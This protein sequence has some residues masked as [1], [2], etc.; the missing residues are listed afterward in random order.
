[1]AGKL[2]A[3]MLTT[4]LALAAADARAIEKLTIGN[5]KTVVRTVTGT[6]EGDL[7]RLHLRDDVY[8][9]EIIKTG[10]RS[11][12]EIIFVDE[13]RIL[14]GPNAQMTLDRFFFDP[15]P[16]RAAFVMTAIKGVFRFASG[17]LP[18]Q[19]YEIRTPSATIG[20]RGTVL[21]IVALPLLSGGR[22]DVFAVNITVESGEAEVVNCLGER[23][24]LSRPGS[25]TTISGAPGGGCSAPSPPAAQP[26]RFAALVSGMENLLKAR[27]SP[28]GR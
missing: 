15:D 12:T 2:T 21:T 19:S 28:T 9:N 7:R 3:L 22:A 23:V 26:A 16:N 20:I 27:R 1:M 10:A 18:K 4:I 8:H 25:S 6:L 17:T 24:V 11:A 14:I 13:T 5:T